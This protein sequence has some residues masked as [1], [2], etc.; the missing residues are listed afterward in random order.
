MKK[1][2]QSI[3][4]VEAIASPKETGPFLAEEMQR[5]AE[6]IKSANIKLE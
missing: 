5:N 3:R 4:A 1:K 6:L 2:P